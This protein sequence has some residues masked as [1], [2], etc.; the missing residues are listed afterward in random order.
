MVQKWPGLAATFCQI[1]DI[2][3]CNVTQLSKAVYR[4]VLVKSCHKRNEV[5]LRVK[6]QGKCTRINSE[7][8]GKIAI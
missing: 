2:E 1:L 4:Q 3:D 5:N 7:P 8:Y 6:A